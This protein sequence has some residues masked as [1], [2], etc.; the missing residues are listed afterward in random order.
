[1]IEQAKLPD[2]QQFCERQFALKQRLGQIEDSRQS[3][4]IATATIA[5]AVVLMGALGLGSLLQCEQTLR[6]DVGLGWFGHPSP[7]VSD[8]TMARSLEG[9]ELFTIRSLLYEAYR[10]G[11]EA[12]ASHWQSVLDR[13]RV[14]IIDGSHFGQVQAGAYIRWGDS[15]QTQTT[16]QIDHLPTAVVSAADD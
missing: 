6:T 15:L 3:P 12:G 9:M 1:M 5:E 13:Y 14:G 10:T 16:Y 7:A 4:Q 2:F 8:T 11:R